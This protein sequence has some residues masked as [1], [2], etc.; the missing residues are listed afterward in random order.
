[1]MRIKF[2]SL[3]I[4]RV[5]LSFMCVFLIST[6]SV[7]AEDRAEQAGKM[8]LSAIDRG[9]LDTAK[10]MLN[11]GADVNFSNG[12]STHALAIAFNWHRN[13]RCTPAQIVSFLISRGANVNATYTT[14]FFGWEKSIVYNVTPLMTGLKSNYTSLKALQ[15][16]VENG[17]NVNA[18]DSSGNSVLHYAVSSLHSSSISSGT[19]KERVSGLS[20]IAYLISKGANPNHKN[21]KGVTPFLAFA[22][23]LPAQGANTQSSQLSL[24]KIMI[25]YGADP[26]SSVNGVKAIDLAARR[27]NVPVYQYLLGLENGSI[28]KPEPSSVP[29]PIQKPKSTMPDTITEMPTS[30]LSVGWITPGQSMDEVEKVYGKPGKIDDQGFFQVYNYNDKF[31]VKGKLN[32]GFKVTSVASYEK[33]MKTPAGFMV[34]DSYANVVKKFGAV[35]G[36]KFKGEEAEAKL[37]GCT[38]YTYFSGNKQMVFL[39]D[40]NDVIRGIRVEDIDEQKFINAKRKK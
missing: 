36:V 32:N 1:M 2:L 39:V 18:V 33:G 34:G 10:S 15:L 6:G 40:K 17:A 7:S 31:I 20:I 4:I 19:G 16:L 35:E 5:V 26:N 28:P 22:N 30:E 21:G 38:D 25:R 29:D 13:I 24:I 3:L 23:V 11:S 14:S 27:N 37:K 12:G 8:F 9:D